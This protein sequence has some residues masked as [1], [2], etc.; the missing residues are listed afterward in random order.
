M[1]FYLGRM[2]IDHSS[3]KFRISL[4]MGLL[5]N[6]E[7]CYYSK[8]QIWHILFIKMCS[9]FKILFKRQGWFV[10]LIGV[11]DAKFWLLST[12]VVIKC[13]KFAILQNSKFQ[14]CLAAPSVEIF[15]ILLM[16]V[17]FPSFLSKMTYQSFKV[18]SEKLLKWF[19]KKRLQNP[20]KTANL[21]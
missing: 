5:G 8:L 2:E 19:F 11:F 10:I 20:K 13:V 9:K 18:I 21:P 7:I 16:G 12:L 14:S 4:E 17:Q 1:S 15:E 6:F 3:I